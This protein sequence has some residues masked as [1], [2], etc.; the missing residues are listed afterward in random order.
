MIVMLVG[1]IAGCGGGNNQ[2]LSEHALVGTWNW[3][4]NAFW[5]YVFNGDGTG[6]RGLPDSLDSFTWSIR[7]EGHVRMNVRG[8][9]GNE[10]WNYTISGDILT[11]DSRQIAGMTYNYINA[12]AAPAIDLEL[13]GAWNWDD[14]AFW[15]YVFSADGTGVRGFPDSLDSFNWSIQGDGHVRMDVRGHG[16]EEWNFTISGDILTLES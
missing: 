14:N 4:D 7:G 5:Q 16:Q 1:I 9:T 11:L 13:V 15:Q 12:D 6:T 10:E 2:N 3:D 8:Q